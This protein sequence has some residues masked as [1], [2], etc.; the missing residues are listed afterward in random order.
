MQAKYK[1]VIVL[2][3]LFRKMGI[4]SGEI[5]GIYDSDM[6]KLVYAYKNYKKVYINKSFPYDITKE[7]LDLAN[8]DLKE[9]T[10]DQE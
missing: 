8:K 7:I 2:Q 6:E 3:E 5:D 1:D 4:Y 9:L 10:N